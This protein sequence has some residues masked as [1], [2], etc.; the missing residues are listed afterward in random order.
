[1]KN[2]LPRFLSVLAI[3]LMLLG[4]DGDPGAKTGKQVVLN[5]GEVHEGWFFASGDQVLILGTVEG[6]VYCAGGMV[7][8]DGTI[9]GD[10]LVAGGSVIINGLVSDDVRAA[11][12]NFECS[13]NIGKNL[14]VAGGN[15]HLLKTAVV[16]GGLLAAGGEIRVGGDVGRDVRVAGGQVQFEGIVGGNVRCAA[17]QVL[18][19]PG[20]AIHGDLYA[21]VKDPRH[22]QI[23]PGTVDGSVE[24]TTEKPEIRGSILGFSVGHFWFKI[25]WAVS[26]LITAIV[27]IFLIPR[28]VEACGRAIWQHPGWSLLWGFVGL[29]VT[30]IA[31][32]AL[33][34]ILVG[35]PLGI[36]LFVLY[37]WSLYLSQMALGVVVGQRVFM[38]ESTGRLMLAAIAGIVLV[39]VLT[40]VPYLRTLVVIAGLLLG[41]GGII[42]AVRQ[43]FASR[44][45]MSPPLA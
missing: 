38:P 17:E 9:N 33:C 28:S 8:I 25:V 4:C 42:E 29:I 18:T 45:R 20:A 13:G 37:L 43:R 31:A 27:L 35:I 34:L 30:P 14:T 10:L 6:D 7:Q 21:I 26:L 40:F 12:G 36:F 19:L 39:Q 23:A 16:G 3:A 44:A 5:A 22:A 41:L 11:G 15:V 32:I 1:M 2:F 24:V